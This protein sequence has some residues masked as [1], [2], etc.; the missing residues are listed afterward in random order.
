MSPSST[1]VCQAFPQ[2]RC[3]VTELPSTEI[4]YLQ[5][6][7]VWKYVDSRLVCIRSTTDRHDTGYKTYLAFVHQLTPWDL[8]NDALSLS[9]PE[10]HLAK[11][12]TQGYEEINMG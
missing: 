1:Y 4:K 3:E 8:W 2:P 12:M 7:I 9:H 10:G 11:L 6:G 5:E